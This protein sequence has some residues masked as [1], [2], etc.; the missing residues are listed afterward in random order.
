MTEQQVLQIA[1]QA[2]I[3]GATMA[4]PIML[5]AM[6]VGLLVSLFQSVTQI[7]EATLTF[8][9]KVLVVGLVMTVAG[10]WMLGVFTAYVH[11][12]F[13]SVPQLLAGG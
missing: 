9:P 2:M 7:Q 13:A 11:A 10:H 5:S 1:S 8:V 4:A 6:A 3:T 12:L